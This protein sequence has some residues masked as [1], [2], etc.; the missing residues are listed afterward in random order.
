MLTA[1]GQA[2]SAY[3]LSHGR[4]A[5]ATLGVSLPTFALST[6]RVG[7]TLRL[8]L[9]ADVQFKMMTL[10]TVTVRE[11]CVEYFSMI[12]HSENDNNSG[13][14]ERTHVLVNSFAFQ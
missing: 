3:L 10:E 9:H 7:H 14:A 11:L 5:L 1:N 13:N 12:V 6:V 4:L 2:C 8:T